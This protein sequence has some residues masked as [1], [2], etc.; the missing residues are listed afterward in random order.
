MNLENITLSAG[1]LRRTC[2]MGPRVWNVQSSQPQG[3]ES[4]RG[5]WGLG[6]GVGVRGAVSFGVRLDRGARHTPS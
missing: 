2:C 3:T 5:H 6:E 4:G 1:I